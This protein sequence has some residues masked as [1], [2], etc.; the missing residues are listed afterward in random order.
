MTVEETIRPWQF[1]VKLECNAK[2]WIQPS[3]HV[4]SDKA[5]AEELAVILLERTVKQLKLS[6][7]KVATSILETVVPNGTGINKNE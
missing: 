2:G 3:I 6:K 1:S 7:V 5:D 4:Y